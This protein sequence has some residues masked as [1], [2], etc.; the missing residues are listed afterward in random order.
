LTR[1]GEQGVRWYLVVDPETNRMQALRLGH[2]HRSEDRLAAGDP[3]SLF[4]DIRAACRLCVD[5]AKL[6]LRERK[7]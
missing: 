5:E 2:D 6:V 3:R 1:I 4:I 7:G